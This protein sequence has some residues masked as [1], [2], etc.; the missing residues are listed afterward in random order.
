[1][2]KIT[3]AGTAKDMDHLDHW[4]NVDPK[5]WCFGKGIAPQNDP[6]ILIVFWILTGWEFCGKFE[7]DQILQFPQ[8]L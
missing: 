6:S 2:Q 8:K 4:T 7:V 1:M 3:T 5:R